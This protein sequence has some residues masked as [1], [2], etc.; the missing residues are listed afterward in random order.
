LNLDLEE[1]KRRL[2]ATS[3]ITVLVWGPGE[4]G[5]A[6]YRKRVEIREKLK[7]LGHEAVFPEDLWN[8]AAI[9]ESGLNL[10]LMEFIQALAIDYIVCLMASPGSVG[11]VHD[12][13]KEQKLACKMLICIDREYATGYSAK[14]A[15]KIF[16]GYNGRLD[17]YDN[18]ADI[19]DCHLAT[20]VLK[21]IEN[22]AFTKQYEH[23]RTDDR[24]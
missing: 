12:F 9:E 3:R 14:G 10:M 8:P 15:L 6:L 1:V 17:W 22:V 23:L 4:T 16:E 7:K 18:P 21:Q 19:S 5:G 13:A 24:A 11:E 2:L 20:R